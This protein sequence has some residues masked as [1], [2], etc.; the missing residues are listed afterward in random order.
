MKNRLHAS[1]VELEAT[2]QANKSYTIELTKLKH[3]NEQFAEQLE[4]SQKEK[5]RLAGS[6]IN[7]FLYFLWQRI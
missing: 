4:A 5:R 2:L 3:S 6:Y 7:Y 1:N